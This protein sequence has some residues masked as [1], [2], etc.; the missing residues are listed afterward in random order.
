MEPWETADKMKEWMQKGDKHIT[1]IVSVFK[2]YSYCQT[3]RN[4]FLFN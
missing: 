2:D 1:H 4:F 3:S